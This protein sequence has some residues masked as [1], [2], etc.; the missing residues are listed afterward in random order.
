MLPGPTHP[1]K[2]VVSLI[3]LEVNPRLRDPRALLRRFVGFASGLWA[4]AVYFRSPD[5]AFCRVG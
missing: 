2:Y 1:E 5:V 4:K 3:A